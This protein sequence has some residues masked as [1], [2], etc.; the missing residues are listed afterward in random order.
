M[1]ISS[2]LFMS[3]LSLDAY[4]R[5]YGAGISGL[6]GTGSEIG[7]ATILDVDIPTNS[8][9]EGFYAVAYTLSQFALAKQFFDAVDAANGNA[10]MLL[11]GHS[12]GGA[13]AGITA[14]LTGTASVLVDNIGF[15][16]ALEEFAQVYNQFRPYLGFST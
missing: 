11:T 13:L 9:A 10:P 8:Q 12:L 2:D 1:T 14:A 16:N 6:G 7:N 15:N 3:I 4:N 5:G